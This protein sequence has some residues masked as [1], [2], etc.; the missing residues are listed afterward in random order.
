MSRPVGRQAF[1][2]DDT[3]DRPTVIAAHREAL[4]VLRSTLRRAWV[5]AISDDP[6]PEDTQ[7]PVQRLIDLARVRDSCQDDPS[8]SVGYVGI[9]VD[10]SD[11]DQF[12]LLVALSP[13]TINAEGYTE[14]D[15]LVYSASDTGTGLWMLLTPAQYEE[16]VERLTRQRCQLEMRRPALTPA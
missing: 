12:E 5:D 8:Q 1:V 9:E 11:D 3:A 14:A 6:W 4:H 2:L 13:F 16:L 7:K 10:V 15:E